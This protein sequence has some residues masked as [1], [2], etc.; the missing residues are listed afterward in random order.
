MSSWP[1]R[2][3]SLP[4]LLSSSVMAAS[5][6]ACLLPGPSS[7]SGVPPVSAEQR[8]TAERVAQA[9]VPLSELA[10]DAPDSH[11]VKPGDT[12]WAISGLFLKSPWR[13]PELWGMNREQINNPH[14]I[15]PGQ[16]L[17][18]VKSN[19]RASLQLAQQVG[20]AG[21]AGLPSYKMGPK[22]RATRVDDSP[23]SSIPQHLIEPFLNEAVVFNADDLALAPRIVAAQD[24]RVLLT[25][26]DLAY[27]RGDFSQATDYRIFRRAVPLRD[28]STGQVLGYEARYV[29][30]A[31]LK[32]QGEQR[33]LAGGKTETVPATLTIKSVHEEVNAGDRLS[34][35]LQRDF[36]RYVPHAP[37]G[38]MRG[39]IVSVYGDALTAG[40][41]QVV[42]LNRGAADG[43]E[44][45][46]VL[47]L[48][49]SGRTIKDSTAAKPDMLQLP[50]ER[51]GTL[52]VFQVYQRVSY[53]LIVAAQA[54]VRAGDRFTQP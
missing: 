35:V 24:G 28:P 40:Q 29:G 33:Q 50:D 19:G 37:A 25:Q 41:N 3:P 10:A 36:T 9:G 4:K 44:R 14:L 31:S 49:Q 22:V 46:H 8:E 54:P 5:A 6:L 32:R 13:W 47:A 7:A 30:T 38:E 45:G 27:A 51:H 12:L 17:V 18:L 42:A 43:L 53:A 15:Y 34:P 2:S 1:M 52:F 20:S 11:T 26:G 23:I 48:W 16:V 21:T 39:Q